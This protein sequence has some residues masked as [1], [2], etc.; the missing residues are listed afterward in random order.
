[1]LIYHV[2]TMKSGTTYLQNILQKNKQQLLTQGWR[3]PGKRLNQQHNIYDLVPDS[4]PW[5]VPSSAK[6]SGELAK[7][8]ANQ[9]KKKSSENII[10]SAEVLSCLDEKGIE[11]VIGHF[12]Q[13]D[14]IIFTIRSLQKVIP[15]AWQ[16]YIKGGGKLSLDKF[17]NKMDSD[18]QTLDGMWKIYAYGNQ[19]RRWSKY[20]PVTSVIVPNS[21]VKNE[22]ATLFFEAAGIGLDQLNLDIKNSE[23]N[24]SLGYEIAEIVR[25]L[26]AK[27]KLSTTDRN[28]FLK[29]VV[30]PKL[31]NIKSSKIYLSQK[32]LDLCQNWVKEETTILK[33]FSNELIGETDYLSTEQYKPLSTSSCNDVF[34]IASELINTMIKY[35]NK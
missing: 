3:Y 35:G 18:R 33:E 30:F 34:N 2:G 13:P 22:L 21:G 25:F 15:S 12:G 8:L 7:G 5:S 27:H 26:N 23:S 17:V 14:K 6:K 24:L 19:V 28:M 1:M 29:K 4:V 20:A 31:G 10:L 9:I 11:E 16:Q 32:Q